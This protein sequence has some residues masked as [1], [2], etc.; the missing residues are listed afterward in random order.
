[1]RSIYLL[2]IVMMF[3]IAACGGGA[4]AH[5]KPTD[6]IKVGDANSGQQIFET[7][8]GDAPPCA[9][10]HVTDSERGKMGAPSLQ[11]IASRAGNRVEGMDATS[12]LHQSIV[13]PTAFDADPDGTTRMYEHFREALTEEQISDLIAYLLTLQ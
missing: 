4:E 10:C 3:G 8:H 1:M 2:L 11:G 9:M 5:N 6:A 7:Q 13:D 12:Y